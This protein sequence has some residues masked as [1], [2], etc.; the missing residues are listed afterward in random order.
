MTDNI[1]KVVD[2]ALAD[3]PFTEDALALRFSE[4]QKNALRYIALKGV[5]LHWAGR[6]WRI[7]ATHLAFDL[8]R[9]SCREA[10]EGI[11]KVPNSVYSAKTV[12]A[13]ERMAKANRR[14]ATTIEQWD[15]DDFA[16]NT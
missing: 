10:A 16:F 15:A 4:Q 11:G 5:W 13:V 12:A 6:R 9:Q 8:A 7:E 2:A 1:I 3:S 14:Q